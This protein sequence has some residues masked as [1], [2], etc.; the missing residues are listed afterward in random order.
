MYEHVGSYKLASV[1]TLLLGHFGSADDPELRQ[2]TLYRG[3]FQVMSKR[4]VRTNLPS[5]CWWDLRMSVLK[6]DTA[7]VAYLDIDMLHELEKLTIV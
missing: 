6:S 5:H 1:L 4:I 2:Q 7:Q 3:F